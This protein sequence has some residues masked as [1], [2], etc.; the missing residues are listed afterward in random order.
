MKTVE[1]GCV[2][3]SR[4]LHTRGAKSTRYLEPIQDI[5]ELNFRPK[6]NSF[7]LSRGP[8][9]TNSNQCFFGGCPNQEI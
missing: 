2:Y 3:G 7:L 9:V 4:S 1:Q 5:V 8:D 6:N